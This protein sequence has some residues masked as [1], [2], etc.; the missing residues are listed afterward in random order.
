GNPP[1]I[2]TDWPAVVFN[3]YE[4]G[5]SLYVTGDLEN[6]LAHRGTFIRLLRQIA[7]KPFQIEADAPKCVEMTLLHQRD[8]SLYIINLLNF[9]FQ[10]HLLSNVPI[11]G[12]K[13][14]VRL[15]RKDVKKLVMLPE[16]K[17]LEYRF[18]DGLL[19][20]TVPKLN[21]FKMIALEYR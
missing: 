1:G 3:K 14:K 5:C 10:D 17:E 9:H 11:E 20:F 19:E 4:G 13:V 18:E 16:K 6:N 8:K 12:I 2:T 15:N 7:T 21:I